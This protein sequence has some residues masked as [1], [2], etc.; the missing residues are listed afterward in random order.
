ME[1]KKVMEDL[2]SQME[3]FIQENG[4]TT[5]HM[6]KVNSRAYQ[7]ITKRK[8]TMVNGKMVRCTAVVSRNGKMVLYT[9]E[10]SQTERKK[11]KVFSTGQ[12]E[13]N[14]RVTTRM[15]LEMVKEHSSGKN[16]LLH[17]FF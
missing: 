12:M 1:K 4:S 11:A 5:N 13:T 15:T 3:A 16:N 10:D 17:S 14:T 6:V 9:R 8:C 7:K 2:Y